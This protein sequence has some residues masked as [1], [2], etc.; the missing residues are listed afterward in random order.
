M[1]ETTTWELTGSVFPMEATIDQV[2]RI[3]LPK[4]LRDRL[5]LTPGS[6]VDISPASAPDSLLRELA[7]LNIT[8]GAVY[9]AFIGLT[10]RE[11]KA[12]LITR[13]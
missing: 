5:G 4:P 2:G 7:A 8:G 13:D 12:T 3:C 10:A 6:T 9:D 11:S 1:P